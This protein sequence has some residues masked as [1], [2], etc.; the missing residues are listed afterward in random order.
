MSPR[1]VPVI[2]LALLVGLHAQLWL[3]RGSVP[4]VNE[5]R[6]QIVLQNAANEQA[7]QV[8]ARQASEVEDLKEG[9]DMVEEKARSELGMVKPNEVYVQFTAQ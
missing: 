9:L 3:G 4:S 7:R 8:N 5:M 2:L 1:I 6:R